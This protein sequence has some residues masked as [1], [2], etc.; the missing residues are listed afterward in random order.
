MIS[1]DRPDATPTA[2]RVGRDDAALLEYRVHLARKNPGGAV[3]V[4]V[5]AVL[6][7]CIGQFVLGSPL[8]AAVGVIAIL[9]STSEFVL[10]IRY[11]LTGEKATAAYGL[12]RLEI[13]WARVRRVR[14]GAAALRLSPFA[15]AHRL[16][17]F[18]GITLWY[19]PEGEPG[20][21]DDLLRFV[22]ERAPGARVDG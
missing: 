1:P 19:A 14:C 9:G 5:F 18:R 22:R 13:E 20:S 10:P 8:F 2:P 16:D 6:A 17:A 3:A 21:R 7:A 4:A 15:V 12:A 11:T